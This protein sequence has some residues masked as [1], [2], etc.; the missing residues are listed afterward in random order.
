MSRCDYALLKRSLREAFCAVGCDAAA[1]IALR[2]IAT[3]TIIFLLSILI[4]LNCTVRSSLTYYPMHSSL[5]AIS[6]QI[7]VLDFKR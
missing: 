5:L 1:G 7:E 6:G 4:K 2:K 3:G